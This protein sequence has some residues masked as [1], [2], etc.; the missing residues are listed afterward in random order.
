MAARKK[1]PRPPAGPPTIHEAAPASGPSG[2]VLKG[3]AIDFD[4]AVARRSAGLD[5][6][7]CGDNLAANRNLARQIE[8]TVGPPTRPQPPH[9]DAGPSALP[10]F[11]QQSRSPEGHAFYETENPRKKARKQP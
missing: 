5:I 2:A 3:P 1:K 10:H 7:V 11:H 8:A 6:V 9:E 4:A